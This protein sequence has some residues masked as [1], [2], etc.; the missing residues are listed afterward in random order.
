[1]TEMWTR[2]SCQ[3]SLLLACVSNANDRFK[4]KTCLD[5]WLLDVSG[6]CPACVR[7]VRDQADATG[8]EQGARP[9]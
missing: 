1:M 3:F 8:I 2:L 9:E 4:K 6:R 5:P 7:P